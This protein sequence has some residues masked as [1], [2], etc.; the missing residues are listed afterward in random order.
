MG[1]RDSVEL[2]TAPLTGGG[3]IRENME[4]MEKKHDDENENDTFDE[5][6]TESE[7]SSVIS[8]N[9]HITIGNSIDNENNKYSNYLKELNGKLKN[10][11]DCVE[12]EWIRKMSIQGEMRTKIHKLEKMNFEK[13]NE[14][15][16]LENEIRNKVNEIS[17]LEHEKSGLN[18]RIVS[19]EHECQRHLD[20][21]RIIT[22]QNSDYSLE[23]HKLSELARNGEK[24]SEKSDDAMTTVKSYLT[25]ITQLTTSH[26]IS[27]FFGLSIVSVLYFGYRNSINEM[28][29]HSQK[30]QETASN[31][32]AMSMA[33]ATYASA[34]AVQQ[35]AQVA[36]QQTAPTT[37]N[38]R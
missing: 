26:K 17:N 28:R 38:G 14:Y 31:M 3:N 32:S 36:Q 7:N 6:K 20:N 33:A 8:N 35:Q 22:R 30:M 27:V 29:S 18:S 13:N 37:T 5:L 12:R 11:C 34:V 2:K 24:D 19:L 25:N 21:I 4:N 1:A 9:G 10:I 15:S 23:I 16:E